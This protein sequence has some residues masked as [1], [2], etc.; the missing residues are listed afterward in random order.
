MNRNWIDTGIMGRYNEYDK[1]CYN[2]E[3][4]SGHEE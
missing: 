4:T 1:Y 3:G 2:E